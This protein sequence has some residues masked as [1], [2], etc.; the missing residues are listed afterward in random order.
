MDKI[1]SSTQCKAACCENSTQYERFTC[2]VSIQSDS[3]FTCVKK[4]TASQTKAGS[5]H[6]SASKGYFSVSND[7]HPSSYY[8]MYPS[9]FRRCFCADE[10]T[11]DTEMFDSCCTL[12]HK[13]KKMTNWNFRI[14]LL[15]EL[16]VS[17]RNPLAIESS[18][19]F[20]VCPLK[21]RVRAELSQN[22][23]KRN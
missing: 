6:C 5:S 17:Q 3:L 12:E 7:S 2:L 23:F 9:Y 11:S 1:E 4:S 10:E 19:V 22:K 16:H 8:K 13:N 18:N 21:F 15:A 20:F 14:S